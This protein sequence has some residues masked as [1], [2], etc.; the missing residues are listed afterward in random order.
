VQKPDRIVK[1]R[2]NKANRWHDK[3]QEN[4]TNFL[5][6]VSLIKHRAKSQFLIGV[7]IGG[8]LLDLSWVYGFCGKLCDHLDGHGTAPIDDKT[9]NDQRRTKCIEIILSRAFLALKCS[10]RIQWK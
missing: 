5:S 1:D 4:N 7:R 8:A 9:A 6:F 3:S 10:V 2:N